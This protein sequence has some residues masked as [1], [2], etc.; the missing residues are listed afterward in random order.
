LPDLCAEVTAGLASIGREDLAQQVPD[1]RIWDRCGCGESFCNSFYVGPRPLG[2]WSD[3]GDHENQV[4]DVNRGMVVLDVV[5]GVIRHMEVLDRPEIR[6]ALR[7]AT[8]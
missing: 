5:S 6:T 7:T 3:E 8:A 2:A 4:P 1:L